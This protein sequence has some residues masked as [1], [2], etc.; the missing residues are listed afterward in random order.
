ML[1][2]L[3]SIV[4]FRNIAAC[5]Q[6]INFQAGISTIVWQRELNLL[7]HSGFKDPRTTIFL[8]SLECSKHL[9][10]TA[11]ENC[12]IKASGIL[13]E[14]LQNLQTLQVHQTPSG[15]LSSLSLFAITAAEE[16]LIDI[17]LPRGPFLRDWA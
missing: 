2:R 7:Y 1:E 15:K 11:Y 12:D 13:L 5:I 6:R 16:D 17:L 14:E 8:G 10:N 4:P 9:H 3:R